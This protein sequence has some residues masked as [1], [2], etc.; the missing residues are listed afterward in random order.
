[1]RVKL[2][3]ASLVLVAA[4]FVAGCGG[5]KDSDAALSAAC[6]RQIKEVEEAQEEGNTPTAQSTKDKLADTTLVECAG[7]EVV[8]ASPEDESTSEGEDTSEGAEGGDSTEG[9]EPAGDET[10]AGDEGGDEATEDEGGDEPAELDPEARD[11]FASSC[12][13][14]HALSD[15]GTSGAVGP[16]LDESKLDAA[17]VADKI[18]NGGGGMPPGLLSGDEADAVAQYVADAAAQS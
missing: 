18:A 15:A 12:G 1:M 8:I 14:C 6:E 2:L 3:L 17:G 10:P 16:N 11:T 13:G 4:A 7:Q 9:E 5:P